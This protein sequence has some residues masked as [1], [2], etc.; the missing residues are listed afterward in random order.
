M[1]QT[2]AKPDVA[3]VY[4]LKCTLSQARA[5]PGNAHGHS[6]IALALEHSWTRRGVA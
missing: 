2:S 6:L 1:T 5:A 4:E 3:E